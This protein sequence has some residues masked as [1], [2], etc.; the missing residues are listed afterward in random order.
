[1]SY[2]HEQQTIA[3]NGCIVFSLVLYVQTEIIVK[4][5]K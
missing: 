4:N 2:L 3:A 1:M 5:V